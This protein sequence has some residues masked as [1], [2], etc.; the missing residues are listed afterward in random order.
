[1]NAF[2]TGQSGNRA[3]SAGLTRFG[4]GR[5]NPRR[6]R[7][8]GFSSRTL[9]MQEPDITSL[10]SCAGLRLFL[11]DTAVERLPSSLRRPPGLRR[12]IMI[13]AHWAL[14]GPGTESCGIRLDTGL[15]ENRRH[16][17]ISRTGTNR[18][19]CCCVWGQV[20]RFGSSVSDH[21]VGVIL[22]YNPLS[23]AKR[24]GKRDRDLT[25]NRSVGGTRAVLLPESHRSGRRSPGCCCQPRALFGYYLG[26]QSGHEPQGSKRKTSS[27]G[28]ITAL[29]GVIRERAASF[30]APARPFLFGICTANRNRLHGQ[31]NLFFPGLISQSGE[32]RGQ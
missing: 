24:Q 6:V 9:L 21:M 1:M 30:D 5:R 3:W 8:R 7:L 4:F 20:F 10:C 2:D 32:R 14:L 25:R 18:V 11:S 15:D 26:D 17:R 27:T 28:S 13:D 19:V 29:N 16:V 31:F 12:I 23:Y 22:L